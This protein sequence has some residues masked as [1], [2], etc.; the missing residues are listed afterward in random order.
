MAVG[1]IRVRPWSIC[2]RIASALC[3]LHATAAATAR[4]DHRSGS[5]EAPEAVEERN[6]V[7][8]GIIDACGVRRAELASEQRRLYRAIPIEAVSAPVALR[9]ARLARE[10][11]IRARRTDERLDGAHRAEGAWMSEMRKRERLFIT[12]ELTI[13]SYGVSHEVLQT[14]MKRRCA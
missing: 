14:E 3:P 13:A 6:H 8:R 1:A 2:R 5:R 11:R 12:H 7:E 10:R 9:A 4:V